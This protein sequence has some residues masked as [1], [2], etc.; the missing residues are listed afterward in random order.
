[1]AN[2]TNYLAVWRP[3]SGAQY[4]V[5]RPDYND[6]K[7]KDLGTFNQGLRLVN[8]AGAA[9]QLHRRVASGGGRA[10]VGHGLSYADFKARMRR[11]SRRA[12]AGR[13]RGAERS[14]SGVWRPGAARSGG[15][16]G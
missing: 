9:M 7:A 16:P 4:W 2:G 15:S 14:F 10:M 5:H 1:M 13:H 6:F 11:T 8:T 12:A 3:G